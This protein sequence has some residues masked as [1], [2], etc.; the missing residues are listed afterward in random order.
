MSALEISLAYFSALELILPD[1]FVYLSA[2]DFHG[3]AMS[4]RHGYVDKSCARLA[5]HLAALLRALVP[6]SERLRT[7][8]DAVGSLWHL[9]ASNLHHMTTLDYFLEHGHSARVTGVIVGATLAALVATARYDFIA[10]F[11]T[12]VLFVL[13]IVRVAF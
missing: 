9:I 3:A 8:L 12:F 13:A 4:T 2:F 5:F 11:R 7:R 6:A 10:Q 1:L